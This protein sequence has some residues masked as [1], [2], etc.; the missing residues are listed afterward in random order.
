MSFTDSSENHSKVKADIKGKR[1]GM[2]TAVRYVGTNKYNQS[3]WLCVCDCGAVKVITR[4]HL[5][6]G[7][8]VSCGKHAKYTL[9]G[10]RHTRLYRIWL[11]MKNRCANPNDKHFDCYGGRRISVCEDWKS[12]FQNF[13]EWAIANGYS[14]E[15]TLDRIDVDGNYEPSNC[16]WS[17]RKEQANN[18]RT[19]VFIEWDG[20]VHTLKE[21][22]RITGVNY[23]TLHSRY[24][25][26]RSVEEILRNKESGANV[27]R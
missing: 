2:L 21:W 18:K 16:R 17:T 11:N 14:D 5:I 15:L 9:H 10:Q 12:S 23:S 1:F 3:R 20:E 6:D 22:S 25:K 13:R 26:G 19:N 4:T 27:D 7:K 8:T 24:A